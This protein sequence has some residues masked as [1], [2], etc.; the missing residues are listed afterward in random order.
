MNNIDVVR[1]FVR[2]ARNVIESIT[3]AT[4]GAD[5]PMERK[6]SFTTQQVTII[7]G[8]SGDVA[9]SVMYGMSLATAQNFAGAMMGAEVGELDEMALSAVSELGNMI[10]G[11]ASALVCEYGLDV[12][13]TPP[14]VIKG[15]DIEILTKSCA[16]VVPINTNAGYF[17]MTVAIGENPLRKA[18]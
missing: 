14:S 4:P 5:E 2:S 8:V 13:I 17:E 12:D 15:T 3:G 11:G 9:G 6:S 18:A 7:A 16:Q 1:P 10:T